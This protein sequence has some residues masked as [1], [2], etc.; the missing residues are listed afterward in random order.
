[1]VSSELLNYVKS[2]TEQGYSHD[3]I[4]DTLLQHGY[5]L[6]VVD[7]ALSAVPSPRPKMG[8]FGKLKNALFSPSKFF[9]EVVEENSLVPAL[10]FVTISSVLI[11]VLFF[12]SFFV[13]MQFGS[14]LPLIVASI[15]GMFSLTWYAFISVFLII[16]II[17]TSFI[18]AAFIHLFAKILGGEGDY[19]ESYK[20]V[21]YSFAPIIP[22]TIIGI[23]PIIGQV[24]AS[25]V[26]IWQLIILIFGIASLHRISKLRAFLAWLLSA[27]ISAIL[28][29]V[30]FA[31]FLSFFASQFAVPIQV[32][33]DTTA[34]VE[35]QPFPDMSSG[36]IGACEEM[37]DLSSRDMCIIDLAAT[38]GDVAACDKL[39]EYA[40][41]EGC[42][43]NVIITT[44]DIS[45]CES[46]T[47]TG[48]KDSCFGAIAMITG[49]SGACERISNE[50]VRN[51]CKQMLS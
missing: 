32:K 26:A 25:L 3:R 22:G 2:C 39:S 36:N 6:D 19:L 9:E 40:S 31:L 14:V 23:I 1:M 50:E 34:Y 35:E 20:A 17:L 15:L 46:M 18:G 21:A 5:T 10:K 13:A 12:L 38:S 43:N 37:S 8:Y 4:K 28:V 47:D 51:S 7:E 42:V 49:D 48:E 30:F 45:I 24:L 16:F 29:V 27:I 33:F 44:K 41:R 11:A